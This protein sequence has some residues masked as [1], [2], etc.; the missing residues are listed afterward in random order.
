MKSVT[1]DSKKNDN[2]QNILIKIFDWCK[3][4]FG[5]PTT[6]ILVRALKCTL[7]TILI[8]FFS[9]LF[10]KNYM[11]IKKNNIVTDKIKNMHTYRGGHSSLELEQFGVIL[12]CDYSGYGIIERFDNKI[13]K[14]FIIEK[15]KNI[16]SKFC[17][18]IRMTDDK[19]LVFGQNISL[20][21]IKNNYSQDLYKNYNRYNSQIIKLKNDN[22]FII[23]GRDSNNKFIEECDIFDVSQR[24]IINGNKLIYN[25]NKIDLYKNKRNILQ[26]NNK[27]ILICFDNVIQIYNTD[28]NECMKIKHL[29]FQ[30]DDVFYMVN[31]N[32]VLISYRTKNNNKILN[33]GI[34]NLDNYS[35]K[36]LNQSK[37]IQGYKTVISKNNNIYFIGTSQENNKGIF[38]YDYSKNKFNFIGNMRQN[39]I[40]HSC[41]LIGNNK[42]LITGGSVDEFLPNSTNSVEILK[43]KE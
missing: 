15:Y 12:L 30:I 26:I 36:F 19:I 40:G 43:I 39:R 16:K 14:F 2:N 8:L 37:L 25:N 10:I 21:D 41:V 42:I 22:I 6:G 5:H 33:I 3:S 28:K 38:L 31:S 35:L 4:Y 32:Q 29:D 20:L 34:L 27:D 13:N 17:T 9:Y 18:P 23:G 7:P 1:E 11:Y 24:K